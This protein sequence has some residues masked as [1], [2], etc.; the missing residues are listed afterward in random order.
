MMRRSLPV[1]GLW[2]AIAL[3]PLSTAWAQTGQYTVQG[4]VVDATTGEGVPGATVE[5]ESAG[6]QQTAEDGSF[7]FAIVPPG[8]HGLTVEATGYAPIR[9][10]VLV[11]DHVQALLRLEPRPIV[12]DSIAAR[13]ALHDVRGRVLEVSSDRSVPFATVRIPGI[14]ETSTNDAGAFRL[15]RLPPGD[16]VLEAERFG[17]MPLRTSV[18]VFADTT[19]VVRLE[20]DSIAVKMMQQQVERLETRVKGVGYSLRVVDRDAIR[21]SRVGTP[22]DLL[23]GR[24]AVRL[25]NCPHAPHARCIQRNP[26]P[27]AEPEVFID[28]R[29]IH[30]GLEVLEKYPV[31]AIDRIE[32][33][34]DGAGIRAYTTWYI[35]RMAGETSCFGRCF[36]RAGSHP[37]GVAEP[38]FA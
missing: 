8:R 19:V 11:T 2:T 14:G 20:L 12:L 9:T 16:Y 1:F 30:C 29:R 18:S 35:E 13:S 36:R 32:V 15:A 6:R 7:S 5:I 22:L 37:S 25:A 21:G 38:R 28:D 24:A 34:R 23:T 27:P 3:L 10:A 31:A 17:W 26:L 4:R 33:I